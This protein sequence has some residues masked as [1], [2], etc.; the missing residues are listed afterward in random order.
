MT[1]LF[2]PFH[3]LYFVLDRI[4]LSVHAHWLTMIE[5]T[6]ENRVFLYT[7]RDQGWSHITWF[8]FWPKFWVSCS[9]ERAS[10]PHLGG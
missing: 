8:H 4:Y 5:S 1:I 6:V 10:T 9:V 3:Q 7:H 2:V